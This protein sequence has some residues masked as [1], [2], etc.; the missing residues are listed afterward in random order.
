MPLLAG[1]H[2]D[3]TICRVGDD[4]YLATSSFEYFPGV[5]LFHSRNLTEW[6]QIGHIL[7]R[8]SQLVVQPGI[9]G[10]SKGIYAPTLRHHGDRFYL[11]TTNMNEIRR[12]HLIVHSADPEG[13]W[14][15]PVY[16]SG[17]IGIDPDLAWDDD[18]TCYLT[19]C[20]V[21]RHSIS[22]AVVDPLSGE[23]LSE[24]KTLWAGSGL[25]N[26]E[27][28]HLHR[29]GEWWYLVVAEGGTHTGHGVSVARSRS[30]SGPF[31]GHPSNPVFSH[32]STAH[33]V[34]ATGHADFVESGDG[35]W[36]AVHLGIRLRGTFPRFHVTGRETFI[37]GIDWVDD[38]PVFD[39]ERFVVEPQDTAF[40]DSF[41]GPLHLR[42]VGPGQDPAEF[43]RTGSEGL[44]L[45]AERGTATLCTRIRDHEWSARA[46]LAEG[47]GGLSVRIDEQHSFGIAVAGGDVEVVQVVGSTRTVLASAPAAAPCELVLSAEPAP[48]RS[49]RAGPDRLRAGVIESDGSTR[50]LADV[51]GRYVSTEVAGGFTGRMMALEA[52]AGGATFRSVRYTPGPVRDTAPATSPND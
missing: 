11:I 18:G 34:Q 39:E 14:S 5:P 44:S 49:F 51:D 12:G 24:P 47:G 17:A 20:D 35:S 9:E 40:E 29:R 23:L 33:P 27:G 31:E 30:I 21:V 1:F 16:T 2:P 41:D 10:A 37:V 46:E 6:S 43:A 28:P 42:W 4:Y 52:D 36:A 15:E 45:R 3:P 50:W 7:D 25:A 38:W 26:T 8:A 22:Q 19:W 13:P 32:R 48:Q